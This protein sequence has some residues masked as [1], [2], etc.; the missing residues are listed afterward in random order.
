M[1]TNVTLDNIYVPSGDVVA[2]EIEGEILIVPLVAGVGDL[3]DELY[4][5]NETGKAIWDRL[6]GQ[7]SLR[8]VGEELSAEYQAPAAEIEADVLG[9]VRELVGRKILTRK[10]EG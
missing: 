6:D 7:R 4:S 2:R 9:L 5:L 1:T 8:A 10:G 3:E